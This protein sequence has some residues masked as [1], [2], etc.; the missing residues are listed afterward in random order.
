MIR[1]ILTVLSLVVFAIL[2][3]NSGC[4]DS[5]TN[6][7]EENI[8]LPDSNLTYN[9]H[10]YSL[11]SLKCSSRDGCHSFINPARGLIMIDYNN[12]MNHYLKYSPSE[13]L[14]LVGDGE[15]SPL[16]KVLIQDGYQGIPQMPKDGPYLNANQVNGVKKW[17]KEGAQ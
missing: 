8:V 3:F 1:N 16:Y 4:A 2:L 14:I 13:K 15:S 10:I 11:F 9:D 6:P 12:I 7:Q 5:G 17:I